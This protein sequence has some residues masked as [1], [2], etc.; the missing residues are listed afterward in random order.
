ME[1]AA[2]GFAET[3]VGFKL[4]GITVTAECNSENADS[5]VSGLLDRGE[6]GLVIL[7]QDLV[8]FLSLKT[9]RKIEASTKPVVITIPGKS[10]TVAGGESISMMVKR[11]IGIDL[12]AK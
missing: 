9:K 1:I 3:L 2:A 11:A 7:D 8:S 12:G 6:I 4:A 10:G 5:K